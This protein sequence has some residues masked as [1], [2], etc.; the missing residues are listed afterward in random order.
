MSP[1]APALPRANIRTGA[2]AAPFRRFL[3]FVSERNACYGPRAQE[4]SGVEMGCAMYTTLF[5]GR[6]T[7]ARTGSRHLTQLKVFRLLFR[8]LPLTLPRISGPP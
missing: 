6:R 7:E 8:K 4:D 2:Q 3:V 1:F 5:F